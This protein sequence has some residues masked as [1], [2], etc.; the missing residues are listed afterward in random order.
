MGEKLVRFWEQHHENVFALTMLVLASFLAINDLVA[1]RYG[2]DEI[3][4]T[5]KK[6][7][8]FQW[9]QSKSIKEYVVK[10]QADLLETLMK[11]G[12]IK[13]NELPEF[14]KQ[15]KKLSENIERYK[16][17]K[18][19][20]LLGSQTVGQENW[21]QD[22]DGKMG[23]ITGVKEYEKELKRYGAAGDQWDIASLFFQISLML[24]ALGI[25]MKKLDMKKYALILSLTMGAVGVFYSVKGLLLV[26]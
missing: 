7:N 19:E 12:S 8:M 13:S 16:K 5:S 15:Y 26:L 18:N 21:V 22:L 2:D 6:S 9:Y 11:A 17:E 4:M 1:G 25:M 10:G 24:G 3:M 23:Q 14:E 20:I